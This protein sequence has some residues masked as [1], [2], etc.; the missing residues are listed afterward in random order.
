MKRWTRIFAPAGALAVVVLA[1]G[2][3]LGNG[4]A[5]AQPA[6]SVTQ[7]V[8]AQIAPTVAPAA[9]QNG[10]QNGPEAEDPGTETADGAE[11]P[12]NEAADAAALVGKATVTVNQAKATA[13][14]ANPNTTVVKAELGD[15]NGTIVYSVELSNGTDVKVDANSGAI[16]TT[17][18][19]GS[20]N[21]AT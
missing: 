9:P 20:D 4:A 2:A 10:V 16:V 18:Q 13:L 14:A 15:E 8:A 19:P 1:G 6:A 7:P 11:T 21:E 5:N 3:A 17:D 12:D